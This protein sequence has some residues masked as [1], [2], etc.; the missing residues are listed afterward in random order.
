[1]VS[2]DFVSRIE[3]LKQKKSASTS[4]TAA[5]QTRTFAQARQDFAAK[6]NL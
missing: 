4:P 2:N 5:P 6:H 3:R 1:M